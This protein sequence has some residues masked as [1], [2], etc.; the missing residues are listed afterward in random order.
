MYMEKA[1][2]EH[3]AFTQAAA[4]ISRM[5]IKVSMRTVA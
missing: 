2:Q 5:V 4:Y 3:K 1:K